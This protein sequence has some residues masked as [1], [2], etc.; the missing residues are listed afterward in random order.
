MSKAD[1]WSNRNASGVVTGVYRRVEFILTGGRIN[2]SQESARDTYEIGGG[3]GGVRRS[4]MGFFE[5]YDGVPS[6][7]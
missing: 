2:W 4:S 1:G 5:T 3:G 6:P 7:A